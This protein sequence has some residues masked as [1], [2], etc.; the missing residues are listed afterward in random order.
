MRLSGRVS[1]TTKKTISSGDVGTM[2]TLKKDMCVSV[3]W[4]FQL[5]SGKLCRRFFRSTVLLCKCSETST[6]LLG[7]KV[8]TS[9]MAFFYV[10]GLTNT[11]NRGNNPKTFISCSIFKT[12]ENNPSKYRFLQ[13]YVCIQGFKIQYLLSPKTFSEDKWL[14]CRVV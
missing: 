14:W 9:S 12:E 11:S 2:W 3:D 6:P 13:I 4:L 8:H 5:A 7:R 1:L 10:R